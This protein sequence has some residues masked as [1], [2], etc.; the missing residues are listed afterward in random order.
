MRVVQHQLIGVLRQARNLLR[1]RL[2][3]TLLVQADIQASGQHCGAGFQLLRIAAGYFTNRVQ[4]F[5]QPQAVQARLFQILRCSHKCSR[6]ASHRTAQ[7]AEGATRLRSQKDQCLFS[8]FGNGDKNTFVACGLDPGF[9]ASEPGI[10]RRIG[11]PT[12]KRY[13][14]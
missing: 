4:I 3:K 9:R 1:A 5:F 13:H 12:Q 7:R 11:G 6:L 14:Q 10:R 2:V 8:L